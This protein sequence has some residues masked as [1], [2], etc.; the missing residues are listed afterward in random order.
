MPVNIEKLASAGLDS[1][2]VGVL[3]S[4]SIFSG[5]AA[6]PANGDDSGALI[7]IGAQTA[8]IQV[9]ELERVNVEGND[10]RLATFQF[11]SGS[12]TGF[13]FESGSVDFAIA[14]LLQGTNVYALGDWDF[15]LIRPGTRTPISMAWIINT[16]AKSQAAASLNQAGFRVA[17]IPKVEVTYLGPGGISNRNAHVNR[18]SAII[19][20]AGSHFWGTALSEANEGDVKADAI[21]FWAE[22]RLTAHAFIGDG[23]ITTTVLDFTPAGDHTTNKIAVWV[24]GVKQTATTDYTVV[25]ATK[26]LTWVSV[27]AAGEE[28]VI[29]YEYT[30]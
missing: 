7:M 8:D 17:L 23:V 10:G 16:Q 6:A 12:E 24:D 22:N 3:N 15:N 14:A 11:E 28:A 21:E 25:P 30:S 4:N 20:A 5:A 1:V 2:H 26:T 9:P 18:F 19:N 29:V 27:P 13:T